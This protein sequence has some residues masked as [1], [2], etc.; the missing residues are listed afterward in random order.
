[1]IYSSSLALLTDLYELTMA[2]GYW[3]LGMM[4][5]EAVFT[6]TFRRR[7][8]QG[9]YAI[10]AGLETAI[11]FIDNFHFQP[12]DLS[13]LENL[14]TANGAP[15]FEKGFLDYLAN[16]SFKGDLYAMPEGTPVFPY[17][18]LL[19]VK[20][21]ILGAQLLESALLN[22]VNFQT[23]IATK[24]SRIAA[25]A[26]GDEV[27]EFGLRR[28]QGIDGALS[29]T[30]A[31]FIGGCLSTSNVFAGKQF[32]IPVK[33]TQAHS[34]IMAFDKEKEAFDAYTE[35]LPNNCLYL[36]DT[37]NSIEGAKNAIAVAKEKKI[38]M[39]GVRLDSGDLA[40][41]SI[42]IRK[43]LDAAG[44]KE[45]KIMASNELDEF[46]I[47]DLKKQGAQINLWGV[48]T[49]LITAKDQ[50]ALDGVYKLAAIQDEKGAWVYKVKISEQLIKTTNPGILQ[51]RRFYDESGRAFADMM[52]DMEKG[53]SERN[54]LIDPL[55][56]T[57]IQT[58]DDNWNYRDLLVP[59][60][61]RG[62]RVY[63][64]PSLSSIQKHTSN[65]LETLCPT[66][67]RFLHPDPY[68]VG[69]EK[70]VYDLKMQLIGDLKK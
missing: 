23:I 26:E 24:A 42:Q 31:S 19:L 68:F 17:E 64:S 11:E 20:G 33:G 60:I 1:M 27:V 6:L 15:L 45:A 41:L 14:K 50:P 29:G 70:N 5:R 9:S 48:G 28:A 52:Y 62:K 53:L 46:I 12:S 13:Y 49:N 18:P 65:E 61:E 39:I 22:I 32:G 69:L 54:K 40:K 10:A 43:L 2:Y 38:N 37:Y 55:D 16:F 3:K 57:R 8:F 44:F 66:V 59:I 35:V 67:R 56:P 51:T 21:P 30:R 4:D 34:W 7:P 47:R 58:I 25:A 63:T 36:V